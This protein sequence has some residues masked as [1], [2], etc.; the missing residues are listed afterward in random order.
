[1]KKLYC[2]EISYDPYTELNEREITESIFIID[3]YSIAE[4][5]LEGVDFLVEFKDEEIISIKVAPEDA[6]YFS[7]F[8]QEM[9]L[10]QVKEQA[11][12]IIQG[13]EV[14]VPD[15]IK[16]KYGFTSDTAAYIK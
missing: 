3:G 15:Y 14:N 16:K 5:L 1:M 13:D 6:G 10:G 4:R 7:Q 2:S 8:N 11:I 12:G 9:F